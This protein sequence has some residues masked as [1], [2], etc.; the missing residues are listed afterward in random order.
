MTPEAMPKKKQKTDPGRSTGSLA[1]S[2]WSSWTWTWPMAHRHGS[3]ARVLPGLGGQEV[4]L[5]HPM[6]YPA[7]STSKKLMGKIHHAINGKTDYFDWAMFN[8]A[9]CLFTRPGIPWLGQFHSPFLNHL[10]V[11]RVYKVILAMI[12]FGQN[13]GTGRPQT[14]LPILSIYYL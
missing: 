12:L 11:W 10:H 6:G 4:S 7:W 14:E 1:T 3:G 8:V 2:S 9:N 13:L 5:R